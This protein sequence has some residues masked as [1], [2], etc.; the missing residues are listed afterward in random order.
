MKKIILLVLSIFILTGCSAEYTLI[1]ENNIFKENLKFMS[2]KSD[3]FINNIN[4]NYNRN[5]FVNYKLELGNMDESEYIRDYG[6]IY[7]KNIIDENNNYGLELKYDYD[8]T[9]NNYINSAIVYNLFEDF[10]V[11]D[12]IIR[13][14]NIKNIFESYDGLKEI[15][16]VFSTDKQVIKINSDELKEGNYY[17]YINKDNYKDKNIEIYLSESENNLITS[18]GYLS[19]NIIKYI[20]MGIVIVFLISILVIY[21]KVKKSNN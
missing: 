5:F 20:L 19:G 4:N 14:T 16:I 1:Y 18:D 13:A 6:G 21:E 8:T 12:N 15:K 10:S 7:N 11:S 2:L 3:S 9:D 17:W